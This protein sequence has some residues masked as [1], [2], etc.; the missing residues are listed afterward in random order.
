[1]GYVVKDNLSHER[2]MPSIANSSTSISMASPRL[3]IE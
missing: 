3:Q 1:M 2:Q